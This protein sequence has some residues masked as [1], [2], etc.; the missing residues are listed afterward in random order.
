MDVKW[1]SKK[2]CALKLS[3]F[4]QLYI[5]F[6]QQEKNISFKESQWHQL[7]WC[8]VLLLLTITRSYKR[9]SYKSRII[10]CKKKDCRKI[11][12]SPASSNSS[13]G[14]LFFNK[15]SQSQTWKGSRKYYQDIRDTTNSYKK[16]SSPLILE[17]K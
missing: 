2:H 16:R 15:D 12:L 7:H 6:S 10:S 11:D 8:I 17:N 3:I 4:I 9:H 1:T 14:S 13:L 5:L